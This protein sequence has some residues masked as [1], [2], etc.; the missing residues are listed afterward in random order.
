MLHK[1]KNFAL[2][3]VIRLKKLFLKAELDSRTRQSNQE[4]IHHSNHA[5]MLM[6]CLSVFNQIRRRQ[7]LNW[8]ALRTWR[9]L[10]RCLSQSTTKKL[11]RSKLESSVTSRKIP[12]K[13]LYQ[14]HINAVT[15]RFER[16]AQRLSTLCM[17]LK[18]A[19]STP[20]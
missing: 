20:F 13:C 15:M 2:S 12:V 14:R 3:V 7:Q 18:L 6:L 16:T 4:N 9:Y 1:L 8:S 11:L 5:K 17:A 10:G 19:T